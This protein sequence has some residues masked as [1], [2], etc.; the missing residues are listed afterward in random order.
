MPAIVNRVN[1]L[2]EVSFLNDYKLCGGTFFII[3]L[4]A[5]QHGVG[6]REQY[7]GNDDRVSEVNVLQ[8]ISKIINMNLPLITDH[9]KKTLRVN[10]TS[11]KMCQSLGGVH[12]PYKDKQLLRVFD[13]N[14]RLNYTVLLE[15]MFDFINEFIDTFQNAKKTST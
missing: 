9:N 7:K 8:S 4:E 2:L 5:R 6:K 13:E 12:F 10:A 11:Y 14:V 15:R 1:G 3:L